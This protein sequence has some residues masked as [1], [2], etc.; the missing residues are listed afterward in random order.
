MTNS[1][2]NIVCRL[3]IHADTP[4]VIELTKTIW[5]GHDYVPEVW[6][7]WLADKQGRLLVAEHKGKVLGISKLSRL[8]HEDWWMQG[9][10][11]H[12]QYEG[13]GIASQLTDATVQAWLEI[14]SG[15][16]RLGTASFRLPVQHMCKRLGF[17]KVSELAPFYAPASQGTGSVS[18]F[19]LL[20]DHE[21]DEALEFAWRSPSLV[22]SAGLIDLGWHYASPRDE[23]LAAAVKRKL[24]WWWRGREGVITARIDEDDELGLAPS[25]EL[26][27]GS[28]E[29][30]PQILLDYRNLAGDLGYSQAAWMAP[31]H[32]SLLPILEAAGYKRTWENALYIYAKTHQEKP[33]DSA[34][35]KL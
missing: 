23:F 28:L 2:L 15:T 3:A 7:E 32:E 19:Q 9:L 25:I 4:D 14:G 26:L 6:E 21:V 20:A 29:A 17:V 35:R 11:V 8:S 33:P 34:N 27:A 1:R 10:R 5:E 30:L 12:P 16:V 24:A 18:V 22:L 31:L 13:L